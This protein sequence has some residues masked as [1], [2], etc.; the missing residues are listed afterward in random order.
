MS[1]T[2]RTEIPETKDESGRPPKK[3][4]V[5]ILLAIFFGWAGG[6]RFYAGKTKSAIAMLFTMGGFGAIW[7]FDLLTLLLGNPKDGYDRTFVTW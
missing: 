2:D 5:A 3:R 7:L 4:I 6:H 1:E